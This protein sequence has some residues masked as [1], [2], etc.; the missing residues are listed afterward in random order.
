MTPCW[1]LRV[2]IAA[3]LASIG[4]PGL[5]MPDTAA[6]QSDARC[7][8][9]TNR[10]LS[11]RFRQ[12]WEQNGGVAVFGF[13][14]TAARPELNRDTGRVYLTQWFE[15]NRFEWHPEHRGTPH[16]V[17]LGQFG[18]RILAEVDATR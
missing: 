13:P 6:A 2:L 15:R 12:Y 17:L 16:E 1:P 8:P 14:V 3:L 4:S 5:I 9:E 10:C 11:G 18:R 7:F